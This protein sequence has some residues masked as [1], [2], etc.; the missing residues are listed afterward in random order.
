MG[1]VDGF[2]VIVG[3][4]SLRSTGSGAVAFPHRWTPGG[5]TVEADFTGAHLLH[6]SAAG[7]VLNDVYR[8]AGALGIEIEGVR[9]TA[10][11]GFDTDTWT[12]TGITYQVELRSPASAEDLDRLL[13]RVDEV[14]EI[15]RAIRA[16]ASVQRA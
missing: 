1:R 4:G 11:G 2:A 13:D 7:C 6:L 16:G 8:E 10:A 3:A 5:V 9:V 12:S 15:P 14:A